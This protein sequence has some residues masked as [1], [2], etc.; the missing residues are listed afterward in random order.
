[1]K[2]FDSRTYSINDFLEWSDNEQLELAPK[3]QR[4]SVWNDTA[5]SYLMDTIISGKPIPKV[6]IRQKINPQTR[7]SVREVVDGQQRLRTILSFM[8]DGFVISKKHN[9]EYGGRYFSQLNEV[10]VEIQTLILNYEIS[11]DLLVNMSDPEVLD[12]F[13][14]L[15]SYSVTLNEQE[16]LNSIHFGQFKRLADNLAH[17]NNLFWEDN[18]IISEQNILRMFDVQL[19]ADILIGIIEGIRAKKQIKKFYEQF[20]KEFEYDID[21]LAARFVSIIDL[22]NN[23]FE[24]GLKKREYRRP[25]V[26]YSLFMTLFHMQ[27]GVKNIACERKVIEKTDYARISQKLEKI[28]YIFEEENKDQLSKEESQFLND[29]RRATTDAAVRIRRSEFIAKLIL[30]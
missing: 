21:E 11:V 12:V 13:S 17:Q 20:E 5:R 14:R 9:K 10:D 3:F 23:I 15:N 28:D 1:M 7:K 24:D 8:K 30:E 2:N 27:Y 26:F 25:H 18:K 22:I 6:F 19:V 29:C 4:R 16:K